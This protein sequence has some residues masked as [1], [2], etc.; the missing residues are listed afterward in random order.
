MAIHIKT[1]QEIDN[2]RKSGQ[3][4]AATHD[5][6]AQAARP[7]ISTLELDQLAEQTIIK[8][9]GKPGFKEVP[10][11]KH[12]LCTAIDATIVHGI[13]RKDEILQEGDL[14]TADCGVIY[15]GMNTDAARSIG[16]GT[17]SPIK[18]KL[19]KTAKLALAKGIAM[20]I[21]GNPVYKIGEAIE[22]VINQNG[23]K[24]IYDLTGHGLGKTLHEDPIIPNYKDTHYKAI[25]KPGMTIAI[26]PIFSIGTHELITDTDGWTIKTKDGSCSV[27]EEHT[28]L[29]TETGNEILTE[30]KP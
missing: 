19:I 27:Q 20:A 26:E 29:I 8:L 12:T 7:G 30:S 21:P 25:L 15:K 4:L 11:Y 18:E 22:Q 2:M 14:F 17:I 3:I 28:I 10:G 6:I 24:V 13:P 16:I 23:F 9:G 1:P 5:I